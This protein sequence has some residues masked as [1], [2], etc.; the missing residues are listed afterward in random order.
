MAQLEQLLRLG[1]ARLCQTRRART[2]RHALLSRLDRSAQGAHLGGLALD[3]M[4]QSDLGR[5]HRQQLLLQR[6][7]GRLGREQRRLQRAKA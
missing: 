3:D 2:L 4:P 1:A 5:L 7:G 6:G